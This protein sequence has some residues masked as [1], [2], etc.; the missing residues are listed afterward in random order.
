V[1]REGTPI[2]QMPAAQLTGVR[3]SPTVSAI[4]YP[5]GVVQGPSAG[6]VLVLARVDALTAGDLTG[7]RRVA[8]TGSIS[9][10]GTVTNVGEVVEKV[11]A[12]VAARVD[13]LFVPFPQRAVAVRAAQGNRMRIV[14]VRSV[15]E[16][17]SWLCATGGRAT[18]C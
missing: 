14:P 5:L 13:V 1:T 12:A 9:L 8:G 18:V 2:K 7:G 4:A 16:A 17:V 15:S 11:H 3:A 10:D 6:L